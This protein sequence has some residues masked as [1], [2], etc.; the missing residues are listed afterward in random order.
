V[1][2]AAHLGGAIGGGA[3]AFAATSAWTG[4]GFRPPHA[5]AAGYVALLGLGLSTLSAF[6]VFAHYRAAAVVAAER[7]PT[8]ATPDDLAKGAKASADLVYR[9]PKDP[10]SHF[11]RAHALIMQAELHG[12]EAEL[13]KA[14]ALSTKPADKGMLAVSNAYL[15][16][17]LHERGARVEAAQR[18]KEG[19][20]ATNMPEIAKMLRRAK[21]CG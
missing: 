20:G 2:Y 19:C 8:K 11:F 6:P 3:L 4:R 16:L 13:R 7:M 17:V 5:V 14:V 18:A 15:A 21:L 1:D 10:K 12:A 9:Y